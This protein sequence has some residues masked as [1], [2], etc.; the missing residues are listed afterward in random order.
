M[1]LY[2]SGVALAQDMGVIV[3][4]DGGIERS[5]FSGFFENG[6]GS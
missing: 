5:P 3:V 6:R 4:E 2:E 1:K